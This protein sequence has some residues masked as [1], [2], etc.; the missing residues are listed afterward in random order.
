MLIVSRSSAIHNILFT[1]SERSGVGMAF[2]FCTFNEPGSAEPRNIVGSYVEQL[3]R[4][5][6]SASRDIESKYL[7]QL[8]H[9]S[10]ERLRP[11][12]DILQKIFIDCSRHFKQIYLFLDG[13]NESNDP[14][15]LL[16]CLL[17]IVKLAGNIRLILS[18]TES[19]SSR[20]PPWSSSHL[21]IV[22]M[23]SGDLNGDIGR[24]IE[25]CLREHDRLRCL[26]PHLK[27]DIKR[28]F[29]G[30]AD[31]S[32]QFVK[33]Q[34][35][36]VLMGKTAKEVRTSL[37]NI[38]QTLEQTYCNELMAVPEDQK[39]LVRRVMLWLTFCPTPM[40]ERELYEAIL[41]EEESTTI[42]E[43]WR[44]LHPDE[45]LQSCGKLISHGSNSGYVTLAH[46]SVRSYM[47]SPQLLESPA[48]YFWIDSKM[49]HSLLLRYCLTY[50][51]FDDFRSGYCD[52]FS[53]ARRRYAD[54]PMLRYSARAFSEFA[55]SV[56]DFD[57]CT[58][59]V[60]RD[61]IIKLLRSS[62]KPRG[63]YFG[64]FI[65]AFMTGIKPHIK[66]SST[67]YFAAREGLNSVT[68]LLL[69]VD[70]KRD[71]EVRGGRRGS[72]PLHVAS[73]FGNVEVVKTLLEAG[74]DGTE[75]NEKGEAGLQW[76]SQ[77]GHQE[78]VDLLLQAGADIR[79]L[80]ETVPIWQPKRT[81][82]IPVESQ[83]ISPQ[84]H[85][86]R[87][88][89]EMLLSHGLSPILHERENGTPHTETESA[90][91]D[92]TT[93]LAK[94]AEVPQSESSEPAFLEAHVRASTRTW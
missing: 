92:S 72:T 70:G 62:D 65:Q 74:A 40:T 59:S 15:A 53:D 79:R 38:P 49:G 29:I 61:I 83:P 85:S 8:P 41:I 71:L 34:L 81:P 63:G 35:Q 24:Y 1:P 3:G 87:Q 28:E 66:L 22:E 51:C 73:A 46:S 91:F 2:F 20:M 50:L 64:S 47:V 27:Q 82:S 16:T 67:L 19:L 31:G 42:D 44:L 33:C 93:F 23:S 88:E 25:S 17:S 6:P 68:K 36:S 94:A 21:D 32:F 52:S 9:I 75:I 7:E 13:P 39:Y 60:T 90:R 77:G 4:L 37:A 18:S 76:A 43:D 78:I 86:E 11:S 89:A 45:I 30:N 48:S 14:S 56:S 69:K 10:G 80:N 58:D 57:Y 5:S 26:P 12:I 55:R 54:W 84:V